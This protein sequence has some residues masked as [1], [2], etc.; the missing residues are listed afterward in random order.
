MRTLP[1]QPLKPLQD[2]RIHSPRAELV[3]ELVVVDRELLAIVRNGT[4]DVPGSDNLRVFL[5]WFYRG[6]S[7]V[8]QRCPMRC[9]RYLLQ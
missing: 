2:R 7:A 9:C 3:N 4:F 8:G 6:S 1:R 5:G